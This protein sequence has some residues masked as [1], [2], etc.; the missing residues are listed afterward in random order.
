[1]KLGNLY[2]LEQFKTF[3]DSHKRAGFT[4]AYSGAV[5]ARNLTAI[6]PQIFEKKY[7]ELSFVN[8]GITADNSGGYARRIQSLRKRELGG[9]S[10]AGDLS[11][12]KG[13]ISLAGEDSS[14][15]VVERESHSMWSDS[16]V[17]E[18]E[19]QNINL[20]SDYVAA[21]NRLYLR[22]IDEIG[23]LGIP[24]KTASKGLLNYAGFSTVAAT[25]AIGTLTAQEM[26]DDVAGLIIAQHNAVNNTPEYMA[27][28]VDLPIYVL[29]TLS[30]TVLNT[31]AS[32]A[33]VL[34][35]LKANFP[36]A[37]FRGTFRADDAGGAGVS[38]SVAYSNNSEAMKIRIP[39]PL[40]V[41][42]I[43]KQSSFD[44]RVDSKYR[45]AGLDVLEDT[46]AYILTG[47]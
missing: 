33:S 41:G 4:D 1:M 35:A 19:L 20:V 30:V 7:P 39:T 22:E 10:T 46:A 43:I 29:N 45:I 11:G 8:S 6:D 24:D 31:A 26:Y 37:D 9:F 16:E 36:G 13:K 17:R 5:L 25:G 34:T 28:K 23:Y 40:T 2:N 3:L 42:E 15:L 44:F 14:L 32:S 12:N 38:H 18:A 21:H 47:L 27:V